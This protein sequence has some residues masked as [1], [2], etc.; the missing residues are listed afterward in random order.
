MGDVVAKADAVKIRKL[1]ASPDHPVLVGFAGSAADAFALME[2]F[3]G[4]LRV[5]RDQLTGSSRS[6]DNGSEAAAA[7]EGL[8]LSVGL[9]LNLLILLGAVHTAGLSL[10]WRRAG[11][12]LHRRQSDV[13]MGGAARL[14]GEAAADDGGRDG[15]RARV[16]GEEG[17]PLLA[18]PPDAPVRV[19]CGRDRSGRQGPRHVVWKRGRAQPVDLDDRIAPGDS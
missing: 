1:H 16:A 5:S 7:P 4:K 11:L 19:A 6:K 12:D 15:E 13:D 17:A 2:R 9:T 10:G 8:P 14:D 3:E 18:L